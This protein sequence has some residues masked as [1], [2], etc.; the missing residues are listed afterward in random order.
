[1]PKKHEPRVEAQEEDQK[2]EDHEVQ[3]HHRGLAELGLVAQIRVDVQDAVVVAQVLPELPELPKDVTQNSPK[4]KDKKDME[5]LRLRTFGPNLG[6]KTKHHTGVGQNETRNRTA[7]VSPCFH[8]PRFQPNFDP[9]PHLGKTAFSK[10]EARKRKRH[11]EKH[12]GGWSPRETRWWVGIGC[13]M[14]G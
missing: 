5:M 2:H 12:D 11:Q 3:Q 8:L 4:L 14:F 9:Q 10:V 1:M 7:G 6:N 13:C